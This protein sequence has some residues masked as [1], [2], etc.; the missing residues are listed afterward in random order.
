MTVRDDANYV[1]FASPLSFA[2]TVERLSSAIAKAGMTL[3]AK[4]DHAAAAHAVGLALPPTLV[5][6]YGNPKGGTLVMQATP[7][8]ALDLPLRALVREAEDGRTLIAFHPAGEMLQH[9][10]VSAETAAKLE[11]AQ[12]LLRNALT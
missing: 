3:F 12:Q 9:A 4:I 5:L 2:E 1:E 10:G 8:A 7:Q 11:P 6:I